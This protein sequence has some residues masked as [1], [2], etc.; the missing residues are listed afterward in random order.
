MPL[1]LYPYT[2]IEKAKN[3][4]FVLSEAPAYKLKTNNTEVIIYSDEI[5][6]PRK[7]V[8]DTPSPLDFLSKTH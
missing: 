8:I 2:Q 1:Q 5:F 4:E 7:V 6:R 3:T